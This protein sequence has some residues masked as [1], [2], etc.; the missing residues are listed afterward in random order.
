MMLIIGSFTSA[1][2][3][4]L[5]ELSLERNKNTYQVTNATEIDLSWFKNN[6]NSVGIS[7]G[8]S[9]P[10]WIIESVIKKVKELTNTKEKEIIHE[11]RV[12]F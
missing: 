7:A 6:I 12:R 4:R 10:D 2:S 1:N 3:K 5:T 11:S 8:A 9:T